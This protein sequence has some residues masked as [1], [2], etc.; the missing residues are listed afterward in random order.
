MQQISAASAADLQKQSV[1]LAEKLWNLREEL[2]AGKVKNVREMRALKR[3]L[4]RMLTKL[5][6]MTK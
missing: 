3:S 4:A 6:T 5:G 1:A 2:A